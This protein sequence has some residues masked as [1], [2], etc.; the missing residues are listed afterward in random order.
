MWLREKR[1]LKAV[2][3]ETSA[4]VVEQDNE[5]LGFGVGEIDDAG[6]KTMYYPS[7]RTVQRYMCPVGNQAHNGHPVR[8]GRHCRR[9]QRGGAD[10]YEDCLIMSTLVLKEKVVFDERVC[11]EEW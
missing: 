10:R 3:V 4:K 1:Y 8:C 9:A 7:W 5:Y 2:C 6:T 11:V